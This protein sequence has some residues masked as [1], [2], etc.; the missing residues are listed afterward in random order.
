MDNIVRYLGD[1]VVIYVIFER[2]ISIIAECVFWFLV[3]ENKA[4]VIKSDFD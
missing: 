2:I 1:F 3:R 4:F